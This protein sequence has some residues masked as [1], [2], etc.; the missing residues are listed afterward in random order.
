M[1]ERLCVRL[2]LCSYTR[3]EGDLPRRWF[4]ERRR[5]WSLPFGSAGYVINRSR[6]VQNGGAGKNQKSRGRTLLQKIHA[7]GGLATDRCRS[8][9]VLCV[10]VYREVYVSVSECECVKG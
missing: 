9:K 8:Y 2:R 10:Y 5:R 4:G 7:R 3:K 1:V 6:L